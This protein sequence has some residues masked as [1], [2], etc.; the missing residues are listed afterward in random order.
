[1]TQ[2]ELAEASGVAIAT[3]KDIERG[4]VERPQNKTLTSLA[5]VLEVTPQ[6]IL[7]GSD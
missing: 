3:L 7:F 6:F 1:M 4:A 5:A 2:R